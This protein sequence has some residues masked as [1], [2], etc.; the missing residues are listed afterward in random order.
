VAREVYEEVGIRVKN[1]RYVGSQPWA[2]SGSLMLGFMADYESGE[3]QID[4]KEIVEAGWFKADNLPHVP[5]KVSI[6]RTLID[7][8]CEQGKQ[9]G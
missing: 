9:G 7:I 6:A 2:R 3:I 5:G 1:I 4:E 8:F